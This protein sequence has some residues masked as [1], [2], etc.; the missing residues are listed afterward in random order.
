[1]AEGQALLASVILWAV[2]LWGYMWKCIAFWM[3][4]RRDQLGWYIVLAVL[5]P[6]F[7]ALEMIYV[8]LV[9]PRHQELEEGWPTA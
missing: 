3:A 4:A 7:G 2:V 9:A 1:M 5:P 8:F 6:V